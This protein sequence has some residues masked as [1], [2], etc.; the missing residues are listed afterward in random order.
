MFIPYPAYPAACDH[1][2]PV[3]AAC[4]HVYLDP[5][6]AAWGPHILIVN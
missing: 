1:A 3:H 4:N 6:P 5:V 2:Y